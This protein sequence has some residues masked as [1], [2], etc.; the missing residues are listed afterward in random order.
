MGGKLVV[1]VIVN[2]TPC[3]TQHKTN[4]TSGLENFVYKYGLAKHV[5][6]Y[7]ETEKVIANH[8]QREYT[9]G[10]P[11]IAKA[12]HKGKDQLSSSQQN[13]PEEMS[14]TNVHGVIATNKQVI[15]RPIWK[16]TYAPVKEQCLLA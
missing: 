10:G 11:D 3:K 5:A 8:I 7:V 9:R 6:Q 16:R 1:E 13:Q 15:K 4:A 2:P 14:L 12:I